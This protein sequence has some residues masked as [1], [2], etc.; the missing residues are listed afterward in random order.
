MSEWVECE[1]CGELKEIPAYEG[2]GVYSTHFCN[3]NDED[4]EYE[5]MRRMADE[6]GTDGY[7]RDY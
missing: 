2:D 1:I 6:A 5:V 4:Y 7:G 3:L